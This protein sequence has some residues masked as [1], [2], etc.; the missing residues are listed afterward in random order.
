MLKL[1]LSVFLLI[2]IPSIL[3][4]S[5]AYLGADLIDFNSNLL[6]NQELDTNS[7]IIDLANS[8]EK[9]SNLKRYLVFGSGLGDE[10][11]I[12]TNKI[13]NTASSSN[14]F[15]S[16]V[17]MEESKAP[18]FTASGYNVIE[19]FELDF[20]SNYILTNKQTDVSHI[21]NIVNS[22]KIHELYNATGKDIRIAIIDTGVDFSNPDVRHSL[23][24]DE[25]NFPVMLDADGQ[26]IILT[27][28]TFGANIDRYDIIKNHTKKSS[29][30]ENMTS[31]VYVKPRN[32]GVFLDIAQGGDGT[33]L[34]VYNSF[35]PYRG[36][37]PLFN[38]T[39]SD[40]MK[41]GQN[42]RDYIE[43][44]SGVYR[45]GVA[46][47]SFA[48]KIQVVPVLVVDSEISGKYDTI[49]P[50]LST[51]WEDFIN[52]EEEV[53]SDYDFDFTDEKPIKLGSGDEF[54]IYDFDNDGE[55]DYSAGTIGARVLDIY[56]V[57]SNEAEIDERLG[58]I[59]GTLLPP[60]DSDG[61]FFGIMTDSKTWNC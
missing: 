27:N 21:E 22:K 39:L 8:L 26:G 48:A 15:F 47:Q 57:I 18:F 20:H 42:K 3:S 36:Q 13:G 25:N 12:N 2:L 38:G 58:A 5:N 31:K 49:I 52:T 10:L 59:N 6:T 34:L 53:T 40:D 35:F 51:S 4:E 7:S 30:F 45:L 60:M 43:S 29:S 23:A 16:I 24:R 46:L 50:D 11:F 37:S 14:G 1:V 56:G 61:E 32:G 33:S 55:Y 19:D 17:V 28:A 44:K 9:N 41:I 54:L